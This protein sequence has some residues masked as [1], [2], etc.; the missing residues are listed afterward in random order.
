ML[1]VPAARELVVKL[2]EPELRGTGLP[3]VADPSI[4][5]TEP[6]GLY[7]VTVAVK[8]T[9]SPLLIVA[10]ELDTAVVLATGSTYTVS[11]TVSDALAPLLLSPS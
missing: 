3:S 2:A 7:P 6:A 5:V 1:W 9:A 11:A 10:A 8:V 4:N